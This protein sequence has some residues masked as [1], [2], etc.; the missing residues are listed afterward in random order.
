MKHNEN[1]KM[2]KSASSS[3]STKKLLT[4]RNLQKAAVAAATKTI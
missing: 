3:E 2:S 4:K 1:E